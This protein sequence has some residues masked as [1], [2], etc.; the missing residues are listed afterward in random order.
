MKIP[1]CLLLR[2]IVNFKALFCV[3]SCS[4]VDVFLP[5]LSP[6]TIRAALWRT[7][8]DSLSS[9]LQ[10][11]SGRFGV[12]SAYLT[13]ADELQIKMAQGAKPGEGGELPGYKVS[14]CTQEYS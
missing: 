5:S 3:V 13:H 9:Y 6:L 12:T 4:F 11:A 7:G 8:L 2:P 10:V 1:C 14:S